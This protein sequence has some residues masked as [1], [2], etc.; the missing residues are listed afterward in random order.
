VGGSR[1]TIQYLINCC[2][3][4][5]FRK[6]GYWLPSRCI[7]II[8]IIIIY[9]R[10][11]RY[12]KLTYTT[13]DTPTPLGWRYLHLNNEPLLFYNM[14]VGVLWVIIKIMCKKYRNIYDEILDFEDV[15]PW[16]LVIRFLIVQYLI[17]DDYMSK[18]RPLSLAYNI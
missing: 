14:C 2:K 12:H 15:T 9:Y 10:Y 17:I 16:H 4:Y 1:E 6:I 11:P 5:G 13:Y 18:T 7:I 3:N 8:I